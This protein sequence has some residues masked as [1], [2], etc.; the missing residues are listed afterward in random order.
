[1]KY[2]Y[3]LRDTT[4][5][6]KLEKKY[7]VIT[8]KEITQIPK[9]E[10]KKFSILCTFKLNS[11]FAEVFIMCFAKSATDTYLHYKKKVS[12]FPGD[13]KITNLFYNAICEIQKSCISNSTIGKG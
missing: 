9:L 5:P 11:H 6:R 2:K 7:F 8:N 3:Y 1:M 13:G 4:S 12:D 10:S